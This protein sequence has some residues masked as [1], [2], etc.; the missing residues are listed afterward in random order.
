M[1]E[2]EFAEAREDLASLEKDYEEVAAD[3]VK[4][5]EGKSVM[6]DPFAM[7][8]FMG[9]NFG[10]YL[11][12][13]VNLQKGNHQVPKI[14]HVNWFRKSKDGKF[15]W[16]GFGEN[17]RVIDWIIRRLD[18]E[19]G[20]GQETAIGVIPTRES[21]NMEGLGEIDW[22]QLMSLPPTYWHEDSKE[23]R[24]F[25]EEQVGQ[26]LPQTIRQEMDMQEKRIEAL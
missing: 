13:W 6:H 3:S 7:R 21:M 24:K 25:I 22:D 20:I 11:E 19:E 5:E 4:E 26:D 12:H 14:F 8:P 10:Q 15:L 1:E 2:G 23:V 18:G 9:Y 16:P 17:I